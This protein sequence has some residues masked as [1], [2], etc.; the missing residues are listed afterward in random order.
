MAVQFIEQRTR[1]FLICH[2]CALESCCKNAIQ[3]IPDLPHALNCAGAY[4]RNFVVSWNLAVQLI[5]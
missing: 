3:N 2:A 5:N 4:R 1:I